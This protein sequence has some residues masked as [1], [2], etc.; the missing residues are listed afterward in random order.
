VHVGQTGERR[1]A[2]AFTGRDRAERFLKD[3]VAPDAEADAD[4]LRIEER[5]LPGVVAELVELGESTAAEVVAFNRGGEAF[6]GELATLPEL[7]N[8]CTG[9]PMPGR[10]QSPTVIDEL[11]RLAR[12]G[13]DPN[14][15]ARLSTVLFQ[16][17]EWHALSSVEQGGKPRGAVIDGERCL[18]LFTTAQKAASYAKQAAGAAGS[19]E[20]LDDARLL[21][22]APGDLVQRLGDEASRDGIERVQFDAGSPGNFGLPVDRLV[23][24]FAQVEPMRAPWEGA[25]E[26]G[27]G[28]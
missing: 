18:L 21:T 13:H 7:F 4:G 16:L 3:G 8:A 14:A 20:Q 28:E 2:F 22:F 17:D 10:R 1:A 27:L 15:S 11:V 23:A 19:S 26:S 25:R 5:A 9:W 24:T 12:S 6:F